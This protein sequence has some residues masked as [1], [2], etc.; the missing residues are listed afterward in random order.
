MRGREV[1]EETE[2]TWRVVHRRESM[3]VSARELMRVGDELAAEPGDRASRV[4]VRQE[5]RELVFF[6]RI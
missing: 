3:P 2:R 4:E 5:G 6:E 1:N